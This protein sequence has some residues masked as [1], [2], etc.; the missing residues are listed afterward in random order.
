MAPSFLLS[1]NLK[2]MSGFLYSE[3]AK[4]TNQNIQLSFDI[5]NYNIH[6]IVPEYV[7][8]QLI[9]ILFD[10]AIEASTCNDKI[11]LE[12][13]SVNNRFIFSIANPGINITPDFL[14]DIFKMGIHPKM[15]LL[16]IE[17]LAYT[18]SKN[19]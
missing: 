11:F 4:A 6:T 12:I 17:A 10:N 14:S 9:G 1:F 7:L 16:K 2:L 15:N 18:C 13:N 3:Y 8:T 19:T 5:K